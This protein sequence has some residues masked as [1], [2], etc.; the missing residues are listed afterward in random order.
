MGLELRNDTF[1]N[2]YTNTID[3]SNSLNQEQKQ[4]NALY[5][6]NYLIDKGWTI[7]AICG[8]LGNMQSESSINPGRWESDIPNNL[9]K[10]YG[11]VQWTPATKYINWLNSKDPT[12]MNNNLS[13]IIYELENNLQWIA[14]SSYNYSFQEF[15]KSTDTAYNLAMAFLANYERPLDPNQ[16]L[17]G[18]QAENWFTYLGGINPPPIET[19]NKKKFKFLLFKRKRY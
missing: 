2:Y 9:S 14:T 12:T 1:G 17:R 6:Y 19:N 15:S 18:E 5:I 11:L 16:P 8:M 3:S 10:G 13:R 7:N 4:I